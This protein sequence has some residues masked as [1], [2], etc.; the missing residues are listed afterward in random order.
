MKRSFRLT[1]RMR[2]P[3]GEA[4]VRREKEK[5]AR[6]HV[7]RTARRAGWVLE[8][9]CFPEPPPAVDG[10]VHFHAFERYSAR[11]RG[12]KWVREN[13]RGGTVTVTAV[14]RDAGTIAMG[15]P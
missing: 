13:R 15:K 10:E 8:Y 14:D 2:K 5:R 4:L 7:M 9:E 3:G 1:K 11:R 6:R 12:G